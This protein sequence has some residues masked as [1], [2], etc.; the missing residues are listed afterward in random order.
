MALTDRECAN[1]QRRDK[2]YKLADGNGL[3]LEVLPTGGRYWRLKYR[4]N[5]KERRLAFG[6]YPETSLAEARAKRQAARKLIAD[7]IDPQEAARD[8][9]EERALKAATTFE[10]VA[11]EWHARNLTKWSA[12]YG[13]DILHRL[14]T[15]VFPEIGR[16]GI[17]ELKP[18]HVLHMLRKI[19]DRGAHEIV[20]RTRQFVGQ[21]CRYAIQTGRATLNP[22]ADLKGAFKTPKR[23]HFAAI[24]PNE[25]PEFLATLNRNDARLFTQTRL[26][27]R[28]LLL[29]FVRTNELI[30]AKWDEI[31]LDGAQWLIPAERMKMRRPH[32]VPLSRQTIAAL[33]ELRTLNGSRDWVFASS[34]KPRQHMSNN[35]V[36]KALER[37]GYKGRMTGHGFRALAMTAIK[38]KLGIA[39]EVVDRQLA[40][41]PRSQVDAAYDRSKFLDQR[42][43]MMQRW[44]D[45]VDGLV[46]DRK[47]IRFPDPK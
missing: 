40:H 36:L 35:T 16:K 18:L 47:V 13:Q 26:A 5:G 1:A 4:H 34:A 15:D 12:N 42:R 39:H 37:L 7:G 6:V 9:R 46:A 25:L 23:Q 27:I 19:E 44:A 20:R 14:E 17:S 24:E 21:I 45:Y 28:L 22:T 11:R 30:Q 41:A 10:M 31:D 33:N 2:A 3:Y 38:E 29:T 8:Q 43:R 32:I